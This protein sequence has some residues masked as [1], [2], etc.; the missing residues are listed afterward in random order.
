LL[1]TLS[2]ARAFGA[3][4]SRFPNKFTDQKQKIFVGLIEFFNMHYYPK[5][6]IKLP[7]TPSI[8]TIILITAQL[9]IMN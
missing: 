1:L 6:T 7:F 9:C 5:K 4:F 3:K 2:C 8:S